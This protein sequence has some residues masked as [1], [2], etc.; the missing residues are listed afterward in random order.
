[1]KKAIK[2]RARRQPH[3]FESM[4]LAGGVVLGTMV[5]ANQALDGASFAMGVAIL[6]GAALILRVTLHWGQ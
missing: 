1:M 4:L 6:G 2:K 5:L 3:G